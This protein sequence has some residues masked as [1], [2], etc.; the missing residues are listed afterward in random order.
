MN[1]YEYRRENDVHNIINNFEFKELERV[2]QHWKK[3]YVG[4]AK[5][6]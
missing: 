3:G 4:F 5:T 2:A 6:G 1:D